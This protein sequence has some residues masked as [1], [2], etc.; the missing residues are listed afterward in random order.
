MPCAYLIA[1]VEVSD[2]DR[3][4]RYTALTPAAIA[5]AGG[6]FVVR[7]GASEV[8]EGAWQPGRVV[9][10]RFPSYEAAKAFYDSPLYV[11]ARAER[12]GATARMNLIVVE[13]T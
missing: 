11:A 5:G 2:P 4:A 6:E 13:G 12:A 3:Y 1:D 9:V 10:V 8:L 7:G